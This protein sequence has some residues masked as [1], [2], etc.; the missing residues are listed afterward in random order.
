MPK[1]RVVL[2]TNVIIESFR[3]GCWTAICEHY[4][5]ETVEKCIEEA[6]TGDPSDPRY[7]PVDADA[8][9]AGLAA[10]HSVQKLNIATLALEFPQAQGLD[11]GELHLLA[12]LHGN[13]AFEGIRVM[14]STADKAAIV[15]AHQIGWLD[16]LFS[17][18]SL[19]QSSG[20]TRLQ[21]EK[22]AAQYR[23]RWLDEVRTKIRLGIIP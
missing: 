11:D 6:M 17:L 16:L 12:H 10:R 14:L 9:N 20:V 7:V 22:L 3:I 18:E 4:A 5:I 15:V 23:T 13:G 19:A 1:E 21:V 2:D 8:L